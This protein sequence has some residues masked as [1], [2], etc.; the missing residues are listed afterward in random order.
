ML[1]LK[2][3]INPN[4][5]QKLEAYK[6]FDLPCDKMPLASFDDNKIHGMQSVKF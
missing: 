6:L 5:L 4:T 1:L 3:R 2:Q